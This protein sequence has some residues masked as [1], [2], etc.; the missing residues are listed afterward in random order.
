MRKILEVCT[1]TFTSV[2]NACISSSDRVELCSDLQTGGITPS[3]AFV[4]KVV[5]SFDIPVNILIRPRVGNFC[6][7][8]DEFEIM[9]EDIKKLKLLNI[10]GIVSGVLKKNGCVDYE[11]TKKLVEI[12]KPLEFTFSRAID[13]SADYEKGIKDI[14]DCGATRILTSGGYSGINMGIE[15]LIKI[16]YKFGNNIIIM[17]GGGL[18]MNNLKKLLSSGFCEFHS[19]ASGFIEDECYNNSDLSG[20]GHYIHNNK[21]GYM[22]ANTDKIKE[23]K[24]II[25]NYSGSGN[26]L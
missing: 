14:I 8:E 23:M 17:P 25:E 7:S 20:M 1:D 16:L 3:Y 6:Y 4:E 19:S 11:K 26:L 24:N 12:S 10:N 5:N 13:N 18:D 22:Y 21:R 15:N 2:K 9:C